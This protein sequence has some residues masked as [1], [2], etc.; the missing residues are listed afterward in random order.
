MIFSALPPFL[1][2]YTSVST[3]F[4][5]QDVHEQP[6]DREASSQPFPGGTRGGVPRGSHGEK[7]SLSEQK[8]GNEHQKGPFLDE[9]GQIWTKPKKFRS[10][11][12]EKAIFADRQ[13]ETFRDRKSQAKSDKYRPV[14]RHTHRQTYRQPDRDRH[15]DRQ[16][17]TNAD[18]QRG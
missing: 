7:C 18:S 14:D 10:F 4:H 2:A 16:R 17:Q 8:G 1:Y 3:L 13:T 15:A 12:T 11:I 6:H 9:I 5:P